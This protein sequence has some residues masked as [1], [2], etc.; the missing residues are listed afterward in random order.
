MEMKQRRWYCRRCQ[1]TVWTTG[2]AV[3][4]YCP[5]GHVM[6]EQPEVPLG[7]VA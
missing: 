2:P 6:K 7:V 5:K 4:V 1:E 3:S